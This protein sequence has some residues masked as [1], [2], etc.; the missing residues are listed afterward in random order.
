MVRVSKL[1]VEQSPLNERNE[2]R[3]L[4]SRQL[5]EHLQGG[6]IEEFL[7][8]LK[9][10]NKPEKVKEVVIGSALVGSGSKQVQC[11]LCKGKG[12]KIQ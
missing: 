1:V 2:V 8:T 11:H 10:G 4:I 9:V 7:K 3:D 12:K 5:S 6:Y